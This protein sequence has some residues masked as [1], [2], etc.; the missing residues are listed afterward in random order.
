M[1]N[2]VKFEEYENMKN[3]GIV[4]PKAPAKGGIYSPTKKFADSLYYVS[5]CGPVITEPVP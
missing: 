2:N 5:G 1:K 4:L 3:K